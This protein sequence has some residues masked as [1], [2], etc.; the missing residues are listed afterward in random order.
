MQNEAASAGFK[1]VGGRLC[2][3]FV[4]TVGGRLANPNHAGRRDFGDRVR[5]DRLAGY[6]D[7]VQWAGL[8]RALS[9]TEAE[10]LLRRAKSSGAHARAVFSRGLALREALYRLLRAAVESWEPP[11]GDVG[12]LNR[13]LAVARANERLE[14]GGAGFAWTWTE[15]PAALDRALWPVVLSAAELLASPD[16][17]LVRRCPGEECGWLFLDESRNHS[18]QWCEMRDCGNL[19]KV[20]R[21]RRRQR[22]Q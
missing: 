6:A 7:L 10:R 9:D 3:D 17:A 1:F 2:L 15:R 12:T 18:R 14:P 19:A 22:E 13:E 8:A 11:P 4:N 21:F 20:R 16:L 5:A